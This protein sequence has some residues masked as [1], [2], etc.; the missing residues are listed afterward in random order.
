MDHGWYVISEETDNSVINSLSGSAVNWVKLKLNP[1]ALISPAPAH[2]IGNRRAEYTGDGARPRGR[3]VGA[4]PARQRGARGAP[5][6]ATAALHSLFFIVSVVPPGPAAR[7]ARG[8]P[9][10]RS[11]TAHLPTVAL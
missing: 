6:D 4:R 9:R 5:R 10:R 7:R 3:E 2:G 1:T 11:F 8:A